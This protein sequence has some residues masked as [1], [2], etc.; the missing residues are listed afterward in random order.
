MKNSRPNPPIVS[1]FVSALLL[2]SLAAPLHAQPAAPKRP[3]PRRG[4]SQ[5]VP[6]AR[7]PQYKPGQRPANWAVAMCE[8]VMARYP[9]YRAAYWKDWNYV[10]GYMLNGFEMVWKKTG[11][12]RYFDYIKR[13]IDSFVDADGSYHGDKPSANLDNIMTGS[14][15]VA[16]YEH[17]RDE[18]YKKAAQVFLHAF[19][20]YPRNPD[21]G[22][23]HGNTATGQMWIDGVFM[24]QMFM[25]RHGAVFGEKRCFDEAAKQILIY[26]KHEKGNSGLFYHGWQDPATP[27]GKLR[28]WA[29]KTTGLSTDVWAEGLGWYALIISETL[30]LMP[31]GHPRRPELVALHAKLA[32]GL[33]NAQDPA[34]GGWW[35]IV[36]KG[37]RRGNFVDPS[38]TAMFTYMLKRGIE[39][40]LL[41]AAT[42][43]PVVK[44]GYAAL[45]TMASINDRGLVDVWGGCDGVS[46]QKDYDAY[47]ARTRVMNA[48]ET[49]AGF[50]WATAVMETDWE[51]K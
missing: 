48:K 45:L 4:T 42:Y 41:D 44:R 22:F 43:D 16:L 7:L 21:G 38:G 31:A 46:I 23:W 5:G 2:F 30:K 50:L 6:D 17:T 27:A 18:R 10:T 36:D 40:N 26:S 33:K 9:D 28:P 12:Q 3:A 24:G 15:I 34:T 1:V 39:M 19:D 32:A 35:N 14:M 25:I 51:T 47:A 11:D 20:N 37:G 8:S 13:Y 49:Y 29:D